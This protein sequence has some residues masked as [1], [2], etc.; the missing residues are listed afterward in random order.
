VGTPEAKRP[1]GRPRHRWMANIKLDLGNMGCGGGGFDWIGQAQDRNNRGAL[2][3]A[4][5][6][7][8]VA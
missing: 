2:V 7:L 8:R 6:N 3:N 4:I 5:M 1:I